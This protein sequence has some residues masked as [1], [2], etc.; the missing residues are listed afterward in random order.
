M[1]D[2]GIFVM[3]RWIRL[4]VNSFRWMGYYLLVLYCVLKVGTS[5][6]RWWAISPVLPVQVGR[7]LCQMVGY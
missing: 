4:G 7:E 3:Y 2:G 1:S 6:V 5:Y